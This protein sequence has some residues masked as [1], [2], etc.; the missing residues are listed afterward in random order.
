LFSDVRSSSWDILAPDGT[1][2]VN[3]PLVINFA[4][5]FGRKGLFKAADD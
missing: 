4:G 5:V 1:L 2:G 3:V